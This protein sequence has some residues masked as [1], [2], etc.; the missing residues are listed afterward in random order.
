MKER[1]APTGLRKPSDDD[2]NAH[3]QEW[4]KAHKKTSDF[5]KNDLLVFRV[6][7]R[8][9]LEGVGVLE[10]MK[11][12]SS[13][14]KHQII[15]FEFDSSWVNH[16][17]ADKLDA[18][19]IEDERFPTTYKNG[20]LLNIGAL[21]VLSR[22]A[23]LEWKGIVW[24]LDDTIKSAKHLSELD[25]VE[26]RVVFSARGRRYVEARRSDFDTIPHQWCLSDHRK[27][28]EERVSNPVPRFAQQ[29]TQFS[30]PP[31]CKASRSA[32]LTTRSPFS[33]RTAQCANSVQTT[34]TSMSESCRV[35]PPETRW[36]EYLKIETD[37]SLESLASA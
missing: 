35:C 19:Y 25:L 26:G 15:G 33:T 3:G 23:E 20:Q 27:L 21:R 18:S 7:G 6:T 22:F 2:A 17:A 12:L 24:L 11:H 34:W 28:Q 4:F 29:P 16:N 14:L 30:W 31:V 9:M 36:D 8:R 32:I 13:G 10:G 5:A 1:G 37:F